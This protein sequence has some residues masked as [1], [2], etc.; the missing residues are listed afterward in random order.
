M[1]EHATNLCGAK[2]ACLLLA[3][4]EQLRRSSLYNVPSALAEHWMRTSL[5]HA[6]PDSPSGRASTTR[7]VAHIEDVKA[8]PAY[9]DE[10]SQTVAAVELG[11]YR[12]VMSV[13]MLKDDVFV[14][15]IVIFRQ[16]VH[17]FT[18]KQIEVVQNFAAQAV[19]AIENTR[20]LNALRE[21]LTQQT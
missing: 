9:H 2:F 4:G 7:R 10:D 5:F 16:E 8:T 12:T 13:P 1:L 15:C 14:G 11:G 21:S 17:R 18:D 6:H 20:L 19:I 3:E